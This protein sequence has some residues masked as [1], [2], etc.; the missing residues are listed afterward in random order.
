MLLLLQGCDKEPESLLGLGA[1]ENSATVRQVDIDVIVPIHSSSLKYFDYCITYTDNEGIE[2]RDTVR[3]A[4]P[5]NDVLLWKKDFVYK[6]L[7]ILCKCETILIPKVSRD[8]VV[9]FSYVIPKPYLFSRIIFNSHSYGPNVS[10]E[11]G[12]LNVVKVEDIRIDTFM[13]AYGSY[14]VSACSIKEEYDGISCSSY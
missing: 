7:P 11:I 1:A 3:T 10:P 2:Y 12:G 5:E 13:S 4:S 14:F 6:S 8:S 9:S